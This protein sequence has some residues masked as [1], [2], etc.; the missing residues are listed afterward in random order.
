MRIGVILTTDD[1]LEIQRVLDGHHFPKL[2]IRNLSEII[3]KVFDIHRIVVFKKDVEPCT[4]G[5]TIDFFDEW[6]ASGVPSRYDGTNVPRRLNI[7]NIFKDYM[8]IVAEKEVYVLD[9]DS[10]SIKEQSVRE[11]YRNT[12]IKSLMVIPIYSRNDLWGTIA[13]HDVTRER[14]FAAEGL[15]KSAKVLSFYLSEFIKNIMYQD[16]LELVKGNDHAQKMFSLGKLASSIAHEINS[17]VFIIGGFANKLESLIDSGQVTNTELK[18]YTSMIQSN[19]VKIS[20]IV[21][22]LRLMSRSADREDLEVVDLNILIR[23]VLDISGESLQFSGINVSL[24]LCE[25]EAL[26]ECKPGELVQVFSNLINN[27]K[28]S[29]ESLELNTKFISINTEVEKKH[30]LITFSDSGPIPSM[31]ILESMMEPFF[32]TKMASAGTG[33]GLSISKEIVNR[34]NGS[35]NID[36]ECEHVKF[37]LIFPIIEVDED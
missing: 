16:T 5:G 13:L 3:A 28:D 36:K 23:R 21:E 37:D 1:L 33:L 17:P 14:S 24:D 30:C 12:D 19:C 26:I 29:L 15:V 6:C 27:S 8:S 20:N 32:S 34:Y 9:R 7:A 31:D 10:K 4:Q 25:E 22:G 2:A 11:F 18:S 35:I